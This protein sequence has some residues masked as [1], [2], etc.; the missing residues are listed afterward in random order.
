MSMKYFTWTHGSSCLCLSN[1]RCKL[2]VK[3]VI[4]CV[5]F[6]VISWSDEHS[7]GLAAAGSFYK[8]RLLILNSKLFSIYFV[9]LKCLKSLQSYNGCNEIVPL[10]HM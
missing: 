4:L 6:V 5:G 1:L 8:T 3:C 9:V 7:P 10:F 2:V